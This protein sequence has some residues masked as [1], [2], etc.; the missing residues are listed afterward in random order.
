MLFDKIEDFVNAICQYQNAV[1]FGARMLKA[2]SIIVRSSLSY[3]MLFDKIDDFVNAICQY[4]NAVIFGG[5]MLKTGS[6]IVGMSL[7]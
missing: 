6:T 5:G 3:A 4:Q 1:I 7:S 2:G